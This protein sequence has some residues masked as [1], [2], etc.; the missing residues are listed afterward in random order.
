MPKNSR[1]DSPLR[2]GSTQWQTR[3]LG[4]P[5]SLSVLQLETRGPS[6]CSSETEARELA[7][8]RVWSVA[9]SCCSLRPILDWIRRS[10]LFRSVCVRSLAWAMQSRR[11]ET[12]VD[13]SAADTQGGTRLVRLV[14]CDVMLCSRSVLR[15]PTGMK[16][17]DTDDWWID[18]GIAANLLVGERRRRR[19]RKK[20]IWNWWRKSGFDRSEAWLSGAGRG[21]QLYPGFLSAASRGPLSSGWGQLLLLRRPPL[22]SQRKYNFTRASKVVS[23]IVDLI[24]TTITSKI[25]S[26]LMASPQQASSYTITPDKLTREQLTPR[27]TSNKTNA[28]ATTPNRINNKH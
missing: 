28:S 22:A 7:A 9:S 21:R 13:E 16:W 2:S 11:R 17:K 27:G 18:L 24:A 1:A 15:R 20:K 10:W 14:W 3:Q 6:W 8:S 12:G 5:E 25:D 26:I 4:R 19:R 23:L